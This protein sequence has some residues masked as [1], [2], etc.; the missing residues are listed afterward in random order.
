MKTTTNIGWKTAIN[1][2]KNISITLDNGIAESDMEVVNI[3]VEHDDF[4]TPYVPADRVMELLQILAK[5]AQKHPLQNL[6]AFDNYN[7]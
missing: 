2:G 6:Y 5:E 3:E 1:Q 4:G 7:Y